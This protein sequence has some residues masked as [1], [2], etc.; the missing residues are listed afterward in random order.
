MTKFSTAQVHPYSYAHLFYGAIALA[1]IGFIA[2]VT[3]FRF[4]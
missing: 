4:S 1:A 2:Y 3:L